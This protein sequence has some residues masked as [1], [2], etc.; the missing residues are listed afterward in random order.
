[1][2]TAPSFYTDKRLDAIM[3]K[4]QTLLC[5]VC[6]LAQAAAW[7]RPEDYRAGYDTVEQA[8]E[9]VAKLWH[10]SAAGHARL[11]EAI[12]QEVGDWLR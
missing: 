9:L 6:A 10:P 4:V 8:D 11:A 1:M 5:V 2:T 7:A 12:A 3:K